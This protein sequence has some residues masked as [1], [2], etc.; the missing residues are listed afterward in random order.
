M[1][2]PPLPTFPTHSPTTWVPRVGTH[3]AGPHL[4]AS[5]PQASSLEVFG[6]KVGKVHTLN[7]GNQ[8]AGPDASAL[9]YCGLWCRVQHI[10]LCLDIG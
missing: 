5:P 1:R 2:P 8:R 9:H 3:P 6:R 10:V 4:P 7:G